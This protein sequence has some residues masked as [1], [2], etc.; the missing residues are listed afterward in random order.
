MIKP[1][2]LRK[3]N[4]GFLWSAEKICDFSENTEE[5]AEHSTNR[6]VC[7]DVLFPIP[8]KYF[9]WFVAS[10]DDEIFF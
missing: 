4:A 10:N 8:W 3:Q 1:P 5:I 2:N 6:V 9:L 7:N